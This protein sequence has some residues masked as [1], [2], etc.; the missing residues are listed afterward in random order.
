MKKLKVFVLLVLT[1]VVIVAGLTEIQ[2]SILKSVDGYP[3]T[4]T[5]GHGTTRR[6]IAPITSAA[7]EPSTAAIMMLAI[8]AIAIVSYRNHARNRAVK[9]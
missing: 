3:D 7:P 4:D 2:K 8:P 1:L 5:P 9:K 6:T